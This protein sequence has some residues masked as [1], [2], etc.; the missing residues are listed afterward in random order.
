MNIC[1][2]NNNNNNVQSGW[3]LLN[4]NNNSCSTNLPSNT[5]NKIHPNPSNSLID[6]LPNTNSNISSNPFYPANYSPTLCNI[7]QFDSP[8]TQNNDH[9]NHHNMESWIN[10]NMTPFQ[11]DLDA[12]FHDIN[13]TMNMHV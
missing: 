11:F 3:N 13:D 6:S 7:Q 2:N 10:P 1:A 9:L 12:H 8:I 5:M 4:I